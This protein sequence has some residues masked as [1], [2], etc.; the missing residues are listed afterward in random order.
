MIKNVAYCQFDQNQVGGSRFRF[1]MV[2]QKQSSYN[3]ES[4]SVECCMVFKARS[5]EFWLWVC[6]AHQ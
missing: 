5:W 1:A 4:D 2:S 6:K 3:S